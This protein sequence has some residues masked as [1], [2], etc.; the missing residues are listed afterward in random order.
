MANI[1][2]LAEQLI[3]FLDGESNELFRKFF[4]VSHRFVVWLVLRRSLSRR[5]RK[6]V[7]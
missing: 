2:E 3:G 4:D 5:D 7:V 1:E 6:S